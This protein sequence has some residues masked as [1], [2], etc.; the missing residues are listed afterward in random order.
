MMDE[1]TRQQA[2]Y[3][4]WRSMQP[5][6][7]DQDMDAVAAWHFGYVSGLALVLALLAAFCYFLSLLP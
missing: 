3:R 4:A 2:A 7:Y 1:S 5:E 6:E